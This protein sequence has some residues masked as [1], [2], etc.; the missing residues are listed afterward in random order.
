MHKIKC[1]QKNQIKL[2]YNRQLYSKIKRKRTFPDNA[3]TFD[4]ISGIH[5]VKIRDLVIPELVE[6][7]SEDILLDCDFDYNESEKY[8]LDIKWYFNGEP[9]PFFQWVPG[10]MSKPQIIGERFRDHIDI[11]HSVHEDSYKSH[12]ALLLKKPSIELSGVYTCK[13][14]TFLDE[15]IKRKRM[16]IY[17]EFFG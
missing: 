14:S 16:I 11:N 13:V 8:Q 15:D 4:S 2:I 3:K 7:G 10:Q 17:C 9:S 5:S 6:L 12:R 1:T